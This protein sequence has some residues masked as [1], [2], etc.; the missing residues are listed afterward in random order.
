MSKIRRIY[1]GCAGC[2]Q[3]FRSFSGKVEKGRQLRSRAFG[4]LTYS[5]YAPRAKSP[6]ALLDGL[7]QPSPFSLN[8]HHYSPQ[9]IET[10][11]SNQPPLVT[12]ANLGQAPRKIKKVSSPLRVRARITSP[13]WVLRHLSGKARGLRILLGMER[14]SNDARRDGSTPKHGKLFGREP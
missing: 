6:A 12:I 5:V 1:C 9:T 3:I 2:G 11:D 14:T 8:S 7:F 13:V 4:V 10:S